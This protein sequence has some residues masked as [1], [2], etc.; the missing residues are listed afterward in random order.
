MDRS[1]D[2]E[3]MTKMERKWQAEHAQQQ[4]LAY[5][6][7]GAEGEGGNESW[8]PVVVLSRYCNEIHLVTHSNATLVQK[9]FLAA[10]LSTGI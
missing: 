6:S 3:N 9:H 7:R 10:Q 8:L 1:T 2:E 4:R 5:H